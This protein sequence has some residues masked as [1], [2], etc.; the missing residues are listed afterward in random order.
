MF[1]DI[2]KAGEVIFREGDSAEELFVVK[3]GKIEIRLG[4]RLLDTHCKIPVLVHR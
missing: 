1:A 2:A 4:N 3:S